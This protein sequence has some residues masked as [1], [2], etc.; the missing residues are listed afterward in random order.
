MGKS[1]KT[2]S[3]T[4]LDPV[5]RQILT[6][7][8]GRAQSAADQ[9]YEAY[10]GTRLAAPTQATLESQKMTTAGVLG[11]VGGGTLNQAVTGAQGSLGFT[12]QQ[13]QAGTSLANVSNYMNPFL[14][15][16]AGNVVSDLN[17]G[18]QLSMQDLAAKAD[19]AGAFGGSRYG[20]AEAETNRNFFDTL[21]SRLN[22][23]YGQGYDT[24]LNA[25]N[26]DLNRD[27]SAQQLNQAAGLSG[28]QLNLN[29][30]NQLA[31]LSTQQ[32]QQ[33]FDD[34]TRLG[35]VGRSQQAAQQAQLE[36]EYQNWLEAR[37]YN[38]NQVNFLSGVM[39]GM[40]GFGSSTTQTNTPSTASQAGSALQT[41]AAIGSL[42]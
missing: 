27:L 4:Q 39:S 13:V 20:V 18:R 33:Y 16:V 40:P 9:P 29:A 1:T 14:Q 25:A 35:D 11:G 34:A 26:V 17:R 12:P 5:Q 37:D 15:N 2:S 23:L 22:T 21:G 36:L 42:L 24:A 3:G 41:I 28:A 32:R 8:Y 6:D 30:A 38:K 10:T 31:N 7:L 19:A